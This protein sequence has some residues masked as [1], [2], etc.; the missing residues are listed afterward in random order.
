[1][2]HFEPCLDPPPP[3]AGPRT[4][5][6]W[7][8]GA[9]EAAQE[10]LERRFGGVAFA[11]HRREAVAVRA[12]VLDPLVHKLRSQSS[13]MPAKA[14]RRRFAAA[15]ATWTLPGPAQLTPPLH[16]RRTSAFCWPRAQSRDQFAG[17]V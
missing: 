2:P 14:I 17:N 9:K 16:W 15:E 1:M 4:S 11:L 3:G 7:R 10:L 12:T 5:A 13:V 6:R 8:L